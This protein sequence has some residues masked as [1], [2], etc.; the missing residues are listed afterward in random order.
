MTNRLPEKL[1]LLRKHY[2]YS[3]GDLAER[4]GIPVTEYMN[5]ENGN[6]IPY[7]AQLKE[8]CDLFHVSVDVMIDNTKE[9]DTNTDFLSGSAQIP[10]MNGQN[11]NATQRLSETSAYNDMQTTARLDT[12]DNTLDDLDHD[13]E[14]GQTRRMDTLDTGQFE[15]N[16]DDDTDEEEPV[17]EKKHTSSNKKKNKMSPARKKQLYII[18]GSAILAS[19]L[20]IIIVTVLN[21]RGSNVELSSVNRLAEGDQF[22]LYVDSNG[23]LQTY[24]NF[25]NSEFEGSVQV[26]AY[27]SHA[28]GL[29]SN[30][31]VVT[32]DDENVSDWN[33]IVMIAAGSDHTVGLQSDGSV[34][35]TG[36]VDACEVTDWSNMKA[37][38]AGD[39]VTA[40]ITNDN[41]LRIS[42][43]NTNLDNTA[44]VTQ[45][46]FG[47]D[48]IAILDTS[49]M[50]ET[51]SLSGG[52]SAVD[53]STL[54]D[55]QSITSGDGFVLGLNSSGRIISAGLNGAEAVS[56]TAD[57]ADTTTSVKDKVEGWSNIRYVA[58]Y[59]TTIVAF[60]KSG[61]MHGAGD[62]TYGQYV[63]RSAVVTPSASAEPEQ[64]DTPQNVQV[65]ETTTNIVLKWDTVDHA[66]YYTVTMNGNDIG[67]F[68]SNSAS[69]PASSMEEG[70]G[71]IFRIIAHS[72]DTTKYKDSEVASYSYTFETQTTQLSAPTGI[73][74]SIV[75]GDWL[76]KWNAVD[77]A[78]S[79]TISL[80]DGDPYTSNTN[81]LTIQS[82]YL[83][84]GTTYTISVTATS[85]SSAYTDSEASSVEL[86]Y[87]AARMS[88]AFTFVDD[89]DSQI[90]S[91]ASIQM[92]PGEH[93]VAEAVSAGLTVP[94]GYTIADD[95]QSFTVSSNT[96]NAVT[97]KVT[98]AS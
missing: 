31:T 48:L 54:S 77:N 78:T 98:A 55:I 53:T 57:E 1:T 14:S 90:G 42:G 29:K 8:L 45:V 39:G 63:E 47:N 60:D 65:S 86:T 93:T 13:D 68:T 22:T 94:D 23:N 76:I 50:V 46:A 11:I 16:Q 88:V 10:F 83:L 67:Q 36:N 43:S 52:T 92:T 51:Y 72:N 18:T 4:L 25:N 66:D 2:G 64:L 40:G 62:N 85:S 81:Q 80:G 33:K 69:I 37:V 96:A 75:N 7:I 59:G 6:T 12:V 44:N 41:T 56:Y 30:G 97:V 24:G 34:I 89:N 20:I 95:S 19:A 79:Y 71:Y 32:N 70:S 35:C 9:A 5:W 21:H 26:S 84:D 28:A 91:Q 58:S 61:D 87:T 17:K 49:G 27:G 38:Y 74:A 15:T 82:R 73:S 3:Q